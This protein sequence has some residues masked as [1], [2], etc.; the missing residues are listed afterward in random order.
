MKV[1]PSICFESTVQHL[2]RRQVTT[3]ARSGARPDLLVNVTNDG[4]FW[5][6]SILDLHLTC[7]VFR[8]VELRLPLVVAAN[9]GFSAHIDRNGHIV[10]QG[11]RR[12]EQVILA[13]VRLDGRVS[14]YN[15]MGDVLAGTCIAV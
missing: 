13:R 15:R 14:W 8:A 12:A 7:N 2:I 5:G 10:Q 4:W 1:S 9:T 3:L 6:S 11:P